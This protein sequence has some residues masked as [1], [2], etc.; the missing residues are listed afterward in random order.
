[1]PKRRGQDPTADAREKGLTRLAT[2]G[3]VRLFNAIA[4]AQRQ[5][6]EAEE[7]SGSRA[8]A[9]K[10]GKASFLAQLKGSAAAAGG[11]GKADQPLVPSA[12]RQAI[13]GMAAGAAPAA[14]GKRQQRQRAAAA[15]DSSSDEEAGGSGWDVLQ[16][17]FVG[18]QGA[19]AWVG[20]GGAGAGI[21]ARCEPG[22]CGS[23]SY[24]EL[25]ACCLCAH[26][27]CPATPPLCPQ[28]AAR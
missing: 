1:M 8:K 28:A 7:A 6:R 24:Q 2:K 13:P 25:C 16:Q 21:G 11:G 26:H 23:S 14:G 22:C 18:L 9:V 27:P 4:K 10:L 3:V 20:L 15:G 19:L 5:L 12:P 17:G